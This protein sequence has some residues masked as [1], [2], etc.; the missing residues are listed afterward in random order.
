MNARKLI[1]AVL[2]ALG[3]LALVYKSFSVPTERKEAKVG[4]L[5][6]SVQKKETYSVPTWLGVVAIVAGG[7]LLVVPGR[8]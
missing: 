5:E 1:G 8:R 6:F 4:P 3:V 7:A 2:I